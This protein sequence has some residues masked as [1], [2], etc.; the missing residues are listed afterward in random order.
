M[1]MGVLRS[2]MGPG[3]SRLVPLRWGTAPPPP[4]DQKK[5]TPKASN[6]GL[7]PWGGSWSLGKEIHYKLISGSDECPEMGYRVMGV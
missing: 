6:L 4:P 2:E 5:H 7:P 1:R 3:S